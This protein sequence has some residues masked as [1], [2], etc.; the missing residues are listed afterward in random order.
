MDIRSD[1][2]GLVS[3]ERVNRENEKHNFTDW[4]LKI[5]Q[6]RGGMEI[7]DIGCGTGKQIHAIAEKVLP[8]GFIYGLD[9]SK[10]ALSILDSR[11][12]KLGFKHV[13]TFCNDI[14]ETD[15]VFKSYKFDLVYSVYAF[16]YS[17]NMVKLIEKLLSNLKIS[18]RIILFG[19]GRRSNKELRLIINDIGKKKLDVNT[20]FLT[21]NE[22][23]FLGKTTRLERFDNVVSFNNIE[24]FED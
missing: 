10:E 8:N 22:L 3:R 24:D 2:N 19:P 1:V 17:R 6:P 14:D 4:V 12:E 16:Y 23:I 13:K 5:M 9:T 11:V 21:L 7:L 15:H 20:D 18:G